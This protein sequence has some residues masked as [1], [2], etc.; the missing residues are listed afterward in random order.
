MELGLVVQ[1]VNGQTE[2]R[3]FNTATLTITSIIP[4][5]SVDTLKLNELLGTVRLSSATSGVLDLLLTEATL[6]TKLKLDVKDALDLTDSDETTNLA[7]VG[8]L[9]PESQNPP[10]PQFIIKDDGSNLNQSAATQSVQTR[11]RESIDSPQVP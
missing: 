5:Q 4:G 3:E 1:S 7:D 6:A 9:I 2:N 8:L 11:N 10:P